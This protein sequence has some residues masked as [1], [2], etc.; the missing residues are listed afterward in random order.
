MVEGVYFFVFLKYFY[1]DFGIVSFLGGDVASDF[2]F[3]FF[4]VI[5]FYGVILALVSPVNQELTD[6]S[7]RSFS[8]TVTSGTG[9]SD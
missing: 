3:L 4:P 9:A 1:P 5:S 6:R 7:V 8:T 2:M